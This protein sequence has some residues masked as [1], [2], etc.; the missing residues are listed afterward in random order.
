[1]SQGVDVHGCIACPHP[2][3][4]P[5]VMGSPNV[6]VNNLPALRVGDKGIHI[7]CCGKN[8]WE[9]AIGS[10]TVLINNKQAHRMGD[11]DLHCGGIGFM[12]NG[13]VNVITGG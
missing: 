9:A 7:A 1:M 2:V 13:S 5:A 12:I 4:G 6:L 10:F 11:M 3:V 8:D